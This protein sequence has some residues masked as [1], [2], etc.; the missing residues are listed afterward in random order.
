MRSSASRRSVSRIIRVPLA[1]LA[2][3]VLVFPAVALAG[4]FSAHL[5]APDHHPK[6]NTKWR[7]TV[8]ARRGGRGLSGTVRYQ[9]VS[10]G[11]VVARRPG[12]SF[13]NGV[14]HDTIVW[15]SAAIGH[16]LTFQVVVRTR[17]GTNY[18][19]WSVKVHR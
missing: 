16:P 5:Y 15:P 13:R 2:M 9:Y 4:S 3:T 11:S 14:Y 6:A 19:N 18:I 8:T 10:F 12:G 17:Y 7:I 1:V